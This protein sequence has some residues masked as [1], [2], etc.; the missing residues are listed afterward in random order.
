MILTGHSKRAQVHSDNHGYDTQSLAPNVSADHWP[1]TLVQLNANASSEDEII[2]FVALD[3]GQV[4]SGSRVNILVILLMREDGKDSPTTSMVT[5]KKSGCNS[6][7]KVPLTLTRLPNGNVSSN[8]GAKRYLARLA[9]RR[10]LNVNN[11]IIFR[12]VGLCQLY[13]EFWRMSRRK[14]RPS[15]T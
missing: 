2:G 3:S 10:V 7:K 11:L 4:S 8:R 15:K 5:N 1:G 12:R 13:R 6:S 9:L 14:I